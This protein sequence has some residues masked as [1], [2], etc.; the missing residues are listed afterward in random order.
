M[1]NYIGDLLDAPLP[2]LIA[3]LESIRSDQRALDLQEDM[4]EKV[5]ELKTQQDPSA[6]SW[7]QENST[8]AIG[9]LRQQILQSFSLAQRNAMVPK[10]V[11]QDL[12]ARGNTKATLDNVRITM[13]RMAQTGELVQPD[14]ANLAFQLPAS[15]E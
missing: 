15:G 9:P 5:L 2:D 14:L 8:A 3:K 4:L 1:N 6:A 12:I 10:E 7:L 13:R 11:H